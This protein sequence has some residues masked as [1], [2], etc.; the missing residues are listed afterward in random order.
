MFHCTYPLLLIMRK[1]RVHPIDLLVGTFV[2]YQLLVTNGLTG[3]AICYSIAW[4]SH[5]HTL[6]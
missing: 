1:L 5:A 4:P 2:L 3:I 6:Y